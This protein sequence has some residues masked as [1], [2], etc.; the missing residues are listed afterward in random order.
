MK[1]QYL[2]AFLAAIAFLTAQTFSY[3]IS[4]KRLAMGEFTLHGSLNTTCLSTRGGTA[5][6]HIA[7]GAEG[8]PVSDRVYR[9][10]N[11]A[12]V[13][14]RSGSMADERK[15]EYAKRAII[16][17]IDQLGSADYLSIVLYDNAVSTLLPRQQVRDKERIKKLLRRVRPGGS[18]NLGGGME[19]GFRQ[20]EDSPR[21]AS[22]NRVILLSDGLANKG[23]TDP[24]ALGRIA[25]AYRSRFVSLSTMGVGLDYNE[26]LMM[27]L[28]EAGGGNYYFIEDPRHLAGLFERELGGI[29]SV[30]AQNAEIEL[31]LGRGVAVRDVIGY[32][33]DNRSGRIVIPVGDLLSNELREITVEL[34]IPAGSGSR[35][36]ASGELR[37]SGADPRRI[38][39][40]TVDARHSDDLSEISRGTN[41]DIQAKA[42]IAISTR[43]VEHALEALD[44]GRTEDARTEF[45]AARRS[46]L[47][48]PAAVNAPSAA[49]MFREQVRGLESFSRDVQDSTLDR[50]KVKKSVQFRNYETQKRKP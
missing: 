50:K 8:F 47:S 5:Y 12:V 9:T 32:E 22:V 27:G 16:S 13:L 24:D 41:W 49:P 40:F 37:L 21:S 45:D 20:L 35:R 48:S 46:L 39:S 38:P 1:G 31:S 28:A 30:V 18:T 19:E 4:P 11:I 15:L 44:E 43:R 6:L 29:G 10:K 23:I 42:E 14:D 36:I 2:Y 26:N 7:V 25:H 33:W 3:T 17:L 34:E